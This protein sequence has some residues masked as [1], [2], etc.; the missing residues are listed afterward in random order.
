MTEIFD[1][2]RLCFVG[3]VHGAGKSTLCARLALLLDATHL[4]ASSLL[5]EEGRRRD[6]RG[7]LRSE[8]D[9]NQQLIATAIAAI[10]HK[11]PRL[12][13]DGHYCL[14]GTRMRAL[15][16]RPNQLAAFRPSVLILVEAAP[17]VAAQ[18]MRGRDGAS[19]PESLL[20]RLAVCERRSAEETSAK[21]NC[22]LFFV[23]DDC[24][25]SALS[26]ALQPYL[27]A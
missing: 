20:S 11:S 5:P 10:R 1:G 8:L 16:L 21:L 6:S 14:A 19:L 27:L 2:G 24:D 13:L 25:E 23:R 3:G 26:R 7:F 17:A 12:I 18:R 4:R 22:P 15:P 9:A